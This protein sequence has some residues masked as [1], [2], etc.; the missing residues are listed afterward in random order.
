MKEFGCVFL[1]KKTDVF[2]SN[3]RNV[4]MHNFFIEIP[5]QFVYNVCIAVRALLV[6]WREVTPERRNDNVHS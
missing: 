1:H 5:C 6:S 3:T 4:K 2:W